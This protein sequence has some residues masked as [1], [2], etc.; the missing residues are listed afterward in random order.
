MS[1]SL[2]HVVAVAAIAAA[3]AWTTPVPSRSPWHSRRSSLASVAEESSAEASLDRRDFFQSAAAKT[4]SLLVVSSATGLDEARAAV[5]SAPYS[6][7]YTPAPHSMDGKHVVITGG[8]TGLGLESAK[9][10]AEAGATVVFTSRDPTKGQNALA[11]IDE[12]LKQRTADDAEFAGKAMVASLDLCDL[13]DVKSFDKRLAKIL[14]Q[15]K[16][17]VL[18]NNAGVMAI[19]DRRLT[20]DGYEKTFQTNHLGHFALTST[21]LPLL[22]SDARVVNVS[23]MG[24]LFT[25]KGGLDL[26]NLNGET[27]YGPWSSYGQSKLE[28]ILFTNEL[29]QRARES[30]AHPNLTAFS[31]HPGA[32]QTDLARYLIGEEKF[33]SMKENGFSNWKDKVLMEGLANFVKTVQEGA[34]TQVFVASADMGPERA[35]KYFADGK[36]VP[37][38][39]FATDPAQG[40]ALWAASENLAGVKF[41]L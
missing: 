28:N 15:S 36:V 13:D 12:Y 20:K 26:N 33:Q 19:P 22:A 1:F 34:S 27:E 24:Y 10:L 39:A 37:V 5:D 23:S 2:E 25:P 11:E 16:I 21:L 29:Q 30:A 8:N 9:R 31:L 3:A 7:T 17:D 18:L 40:A 41:D 38:Q 6:K 14:G 35:G 4:A 32:V